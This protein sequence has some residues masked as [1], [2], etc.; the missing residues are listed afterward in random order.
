MLAAGVTRYGEAGLFGTSAHVPFTASACCRVPLVHRISTWV[1]D[2][3]TVRGPGG[4]AE[5]YGFGTVEL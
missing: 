4:R 1:P 3:P 2:Q 5:A